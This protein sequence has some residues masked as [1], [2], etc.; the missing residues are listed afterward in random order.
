MKRCV[1]RKA[2]R[3]RR[4]SAAVLLTIAFA[5]MLVLVAC[6]FAGAKAVSGASYADAALGAAGRSVLSEYDTEL[7]KKY[8]LFAFRGD[9]GRIEKDLMFYA[10]ASLRKDKTAYLP[11]AA[12]GKSVKLFDIEISKIKANL[13]E[14][15]VMDADIFEGQLR[16]AALAKTAEKLAGK[17][18]KKRGSGAGKNFSDPLSGHENR[19]LRNEGVADSLPSAGLGWSFPDVS[20]LSPDRLS[21]LADSATKDVLTSQYILAVFGHANDGVSED[22][23]F[24]DAE[25]EY[26]LSGKMNDRANYDSVKTKL[27]LIRMAANN[28]AILTDPK[29]MAQIEE[30]AAPFAAAAGIGE[31]IARVTV[32]ELWAGAETKNDIGLMEAGMNVAFVKTPAQWALTDGTKAVDGLFTGKLMKPADRSGQSYEDYL[33]ILLFLMDREKKLLR[34]MDLIQIDMKANYNRDFLMREYY[35]GYRFTAEVG[36]DSFEYTEK[37]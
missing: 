11:F 8:G 17:S 37:Y 30:I 9:E 33:R 10:G 16:D 26:I 14:F 32:T 15:S 21:S 3:A 22:D 27:V 6:L 23:S 25:A 19:T 2:G 20:A 1:N 29:K 7:L 34:V 24:F 35:V 4:G 31:E 12:S 36:G 18:G 13:K 28:L 5:G